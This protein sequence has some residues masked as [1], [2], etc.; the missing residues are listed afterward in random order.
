MGH[1]GRYVGPVHMLVCRRWPA[2]GH[3]S[4]EGLG[5]IAYKGVGHDR[6]NPP[7]PAPLDLEKAVGNPVS[8]GLTGPLGDR[9]HFVV[10][11]AD[12]TPCLSIKPCTC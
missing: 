11:H 4:P 9:C 7:H 10:W 12:P 3:P 6:P 5:T 2:C 8:D 1:D